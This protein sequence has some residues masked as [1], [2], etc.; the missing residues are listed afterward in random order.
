ME[1]LRSGRER[2]AAAGIEH[3]AWEAEQLLV[4]RM[5]G[6]YAQLVMVEDRQPKADFAA[7]YDAWIDRR[8]AHEPLQHILGH[9]PFLELDLKTD[10]RALVPRPET[11]DMVIFARTL[12]PD[13]RDTLALDIGTGTGCIAL[14]LVHAKRRLKVI[15]IDFSDEALSLAHENA[16]ATGLASRVTFLRGKLLEPLSPE[17]RADLIVANLPY[18]SGDELRQLQPEVRDHDP[19]VALV[20]ADGGMALITTLIA[21]APSR[22]ARGAALVLEHA[23]SQGGRVAAALRHHGYIEIEAHNDR[24]GRV[25]WTVARIP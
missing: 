25:R 15:A 17:T 6:N 22:L 18:V 1:L 3:A 23:P 13:D 10:R 2:L 5:G 16:D 8:V 11:E 14:A 20:A 4:E 9:W 12:I 19:R 24:F 21:A 7:S